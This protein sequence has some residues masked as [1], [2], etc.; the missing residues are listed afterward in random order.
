[1][2]MKMDGKGL[3]AIVP[4]PR[5]TVSVLCDKIVSTLTVYN[6]NMDRLVA[7][8]PLSCTHSQLL[9]HPGAATLFFAQQIKE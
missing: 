4:T 7:T 9:W 3:I 6:I 1:M 2:A 8:F 5:L